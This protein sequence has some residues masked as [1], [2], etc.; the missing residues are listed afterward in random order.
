MSETSRCRES[1]QKWCQGNGLDLGHGG[2]PIRPAAVTVDLPHP[3]SR[4]GHHPTNLEGDATSLYWFADGVLDYVYSSHLLEDFRNTRYV[5]L[6]W[7]RVL[8]P[9]GHLVLYCPDEK[10]FRRHC[11]ETGQETNMAHKHLDFSLAKV[12]TI[13]ERLP[14]DI[15]WQKDAMHDYSWALVVVKR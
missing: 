12:M 10:R 15:V 3:Y 7:L 9:G 11:A 4:V 6:E 1:L 14:V 13:M 8:K 2:D 5:L